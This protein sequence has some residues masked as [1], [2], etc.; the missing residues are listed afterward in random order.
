MRLVGKSQSAKKD[1]KKQDHL[2]RLLFACQGQ[3]TSMELQFHVGIPISAHHAPGPGDISTTSPG[4]TGKESERKHKEI[5]SVL[6]IRFRVQ[7]SV[8]HI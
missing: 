4:I 7:D 2:R 8:E 3:N 1:H 5:K 6:D